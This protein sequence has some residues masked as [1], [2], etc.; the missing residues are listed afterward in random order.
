M[1]KNRSRSPLTGLRKL[2][3]DPAAA[4]AIRS[5]L[6]KE[7][8]TAAN[9]I[10]DENA[11]IRM[12]MPP[13]PSYTYADAE[14]RV[15]PAQMETFGYELVAK[16]ILRDIDRHPSGGFKFFPTKQGWLAIR[17]GSSRL[18]EAPKA[19]FTT[20]IATCQ[21]PLERDKIAATSLKVAQAP[22]PPDRFIDALPTAEELLMPLLVLTADQPIQKSSI[23]KRL[24]EQV[25]FPKKRM[26][27]ALPAD[28]NQTFSLK[29]Q[30]AI[31]YLVRARLLHRTKKTLSLTVHGRQVLASQSH[32]WSNFEEPAIKKIK[33]PLPKMVSGGT[34]QGPRLDITRV[35]LSIRSM[36]P[37]DLISVWE[38]ARRILND[39]RKQEQH[40][41]VATVI[42]GIE[43]EW[44]RRN[45]SGN[46]DEYFDWPTTEARGGDGSLSLE[47][48]QKSGVLGQLDYHVGRTLGQSDA[49]RRRTL[50]KIFERPI[51]LS[52]NGF[53]PEEWGQP[54]SAQRLRKMAYSI[55]AFT[56][57]AKR[58]R[59]SSFDEAIRHWEADLRYLHDQYYAEKF[60]FSWPSTQID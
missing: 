40:E 21:K 26:A 46:P 7:L 6:A 33:P 20:D 47:N 3:T 50:A 53:K 10:V 22:T 49:Y 27:V 17:K 51:P 14:A 34:S 45:A 11:Y 8:R 54:G 36:E 58:K 19:V 13:A 30:H 38:N 39:P 55:A 5:V 43:A 23:L 48:V 56:R 24:A 1:T 52:L 60:G 29:A 18:L 9:G 35:L 41:K 44:I 4:L 37:F 12:G 25:G 15:T 32:R 16:D 2:S 42:R 28:T 57:S 59:L 31:S